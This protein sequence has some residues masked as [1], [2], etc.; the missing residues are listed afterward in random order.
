MTKTK[1][2][3]K[4]KSKS[5]SKKPIHFFVED[6]ADFR[7]RPSPHK[8]D[9]MDATPDKYVYR[10]LPLAIAN[11][12]GWDILATQTFQTKWLGG[13]GVNDIK[14]ATQDGTP[15]KDA[16]SHFGSGVLTFHVHALIQTPPGYDLWVCGPANQMKPYIQALNAVVETDWSPYTFTMNWKFTVPNK[17]VTFKE[18]EPIA[19]IFP[20][21]RGEIETFEPLL[22]QPE[23]DPELWKEFTEWR[24][25]R[26]DFNKDLKKDG[27]EAQTQKWQKAYFVGPEEKIAPPHR[28]KL[29][30]PEIKKKK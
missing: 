23:A 19:T 27:S 10:C 13:E 12:H 11:A 22:T 8:R 15:P 14:F 30:L 25:S 29:R 17:V 24:L 16:T 2:K 21:K 20:I 7:L 9:W 1:S 5:N 6:G 18:N 28:T 26:N 4:S 3:T